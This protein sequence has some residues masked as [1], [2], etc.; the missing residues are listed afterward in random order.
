MGFIGG[1]LEDLEASAGRLVE[2]G[3]LAVVTGSDTHAAAMVLSEAIDEAMSRLVSTFE[4]I[5]EALTTDIAGSHSVLASSDWQGQS[6]ENA[7]VL[8]ER[9]QGQVNAVLTTATANLSMEKTTFITRAQALVDNIQTEFQRVMN[10]IDGEYTQLAAA[11][12]RTRDNLALADQTI[13]MS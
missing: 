5:A 9:L 13:L 1:N 8:K 4:G 7:L 3:A 11:S 12:R 2:S 6:R 10:E